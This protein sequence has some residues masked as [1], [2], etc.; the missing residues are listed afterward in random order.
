MSSENVIAVVGATGAQ[1]RGLVRAILE[2]P[3]AGFRARAITRNPAS[4][5][6]RSLA[7]AGVE[8]VR[9]NV[10]DEASLTAALHGAHGVF[11]ATLFWRHLWAERE[12]VQSRTMATAAR[13]ANVRHMIWSTREEVR[14]A[15]ARRLTTDRPHAREAD[16]CYADVDVPTTTLYT[17]FVWEH[18]ITA[19]IGP[20]LGPLGELRLTLPVGDA[21][22]PGISCDDIGRAALGI[23]QDGSRWIGQTVGVAG[24][25]LTGG[26]MAASLS[27]ALSRTVRYHPIAPE[28][29]RALGIPGAGHLGNMYQFTPEGDDA[30]CARRCVSVTRSL[31][32]A[33]QSFD[34]WLLMNASRIPV[35]VVVF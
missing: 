21:R 27:R 28:H 33:L 2:N 22:L 32:P 17:S 25:H 6:A 34:M 30:F 26:E 13:S 9:A 23:F 20:K 18:F 11:F 15:D 35:G 24:E 10:D 31:N 12:V 16:R 8:V 14:D 5:A 19:G 7:S 1:G 4:Q 3:E 29:Y